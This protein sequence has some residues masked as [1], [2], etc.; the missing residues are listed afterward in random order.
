MLNWA[1]K[2]AMKKLV[3]KTNVSIASESDSDFETSE[4]AAASDIQIGP[5]SIFT[6]TEDRFLKNSDIGSA[7][8][9][10]VKRDELVQTINP[11]VRWTISPTLM[12]TIKI[13]SFTDLR[14]NINHV[15]GGKKYKIEMIPVSGRWTV[16]VK[17]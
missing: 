16:I 7:K 15:G 3:K 14:R 17:I 4:L 2:D 10:G 12:N 11:L 6:L 8:A 5:N 1:F 9:Y 13:Y